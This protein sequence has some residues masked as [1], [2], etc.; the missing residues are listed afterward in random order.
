MAAKR[1]QVS[2]D[3]ITYYTLPGSSGDFKAEMAQV[4]DTIF[5]QSFQSET[6]SIGMWNIGGQAFYKGV[7]GYTAAIKKGGTSTTVSA[8]AMTLVS[9]KTYRIND[10]TK[11]MMSL[12]NPVT[13]YDN[14]VNHT[15]DLLSIDYLNGT[16]TFAAAYTVTGAVTMDYFYL[17]LTTLGKGRSFSLTQSAAEIDDTDYAAAQANG[18][19]R[20]HSLGLKQVGLEVGNIWD[21]AN[22]FVDILLARTQLYVEV[23][24]DNTQGNATTEVMFRGIFKYMSQS[25][26]GNVGALEEETLN[27][28]LYVPESS[29]LVKPFGWYFGTTPGLSTAVKICIQAWENGTKLYLKYTPDGTVGKKGQAIVTEA[30]LANAMDGQNEFTFTFK[31]TGAPADI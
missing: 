26:Q 8:G 6:P 12:A 28:N 4:N 30:S 27:L 13:V 11:R 2:L 22:D 7:A 9:G 31:G 24:P 16:V 1:I 21:A 18:G 20:T 23:S 14:A 19:W 10:A 15:A 3:D 29:L 5:G 25:Q 17:P